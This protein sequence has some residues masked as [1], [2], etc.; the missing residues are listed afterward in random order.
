MFSHNVGCKASIGPGVCRRVFVIRGWHDD[1]LFVNSL[2]FISTASRI[3]HGN[4]MVFVRTAACDMFLSPFV[5][6]GLTS[7]AG[8]FMVVSWGRIFQSLTCS[9]P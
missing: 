9:Q 6:T 3:G 7:L 1:W 4:T 8:P 2:Q 5:L